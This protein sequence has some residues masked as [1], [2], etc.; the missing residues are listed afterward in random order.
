MEKRL[1]KMGK[2]RIE[3]AAPIAMRPLMGDKKT[4]PC[5][6]TAYERFVSFLHSG[7]IRRIRQWRNE[8]TDLENHSFKS[9]HDRD[10]V[11]SFSDLIELFK[12]GYRGNTCPQFETLKFGRNPNFFDPESK[13]PVFYSLD[14]LGPITNV[15]SS[16]SSV[17]DFKGERHLKSSD[18]PFES[19]FG[20]KAMLLSGLMRCRLYLKSDCKSGSCK[21]GGDTKESTNLLL[22]SSRKMR[23]RN[24]SDGG[25]FQRLWEMG[26]VSNLSRSLIAKLK[27]PPG[28]TFN[29]DVQKLQMNKPQLCFIPSI[30]QM[31]TPYVGYG[32][33]IHDTSNV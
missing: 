33:S 5:S 18:C 6:Q 22:I 11:S 13:V 12:T 7:R 10:P 28:S 24:L 4:G 14:R 32:G 9:I 23:R 30:E 16:D 1:E 21:I 17:L 19:R 25:C 3:K 20:E 2:N 26:F 29:S 27:M 31:E 8:K 15:K